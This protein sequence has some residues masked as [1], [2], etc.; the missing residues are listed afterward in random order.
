[1]QVPVSVPQSQ[2]RCVMLKSLLQSERQRTGLAV[3]EKMRNRLPGM[4]GANWALLG[5]GVGAGGG[6]CQPGYGASSTGLLPLV[7]CC[8]T[9]LDT[10]SGGLHRCC[11]LAACRR[12]PAS[13]LCCST[14]LCRPVPEWYPTC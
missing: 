6:A 10:A 2:Q 11:G 9:P 8:A 13:A 4:T 3:P 7:W 1:M 12:S 14:A 5:M